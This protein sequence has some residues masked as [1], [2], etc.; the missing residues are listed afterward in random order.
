[1]LLQGLCTVGELADACE[2]PSAT[3]SE[4]F[5]LMQRCGFLSSDK[6]GRKVFYQIAEPHLGQ[7]LNCVEARFGSTR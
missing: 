1:M 4:H 3:A 2:M 5:R 7:I 6:D